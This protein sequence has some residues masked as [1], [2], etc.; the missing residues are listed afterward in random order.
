[1]NFEDLYALLKSNANP[2]RAAEMS[3]YMRNLF[4]FFGIPA[5]LRKRLFADCLKAAPKGTPIDWEFVRT[6]FSAVGRE[7]QYA[8]IYYL[9]SKKKLLSV[10]DL[11]CLRELIT[12]KSWW[13]TI[14]DMHTLVGAAALESPEGREILLA[15]SLDGDMW[16]RRAAIICQIGRKKK[17]DAGLL[18]AVIKNQFGQREFFINKAVGWSLREYSKTDKEWVREFIADSADSLAPLSVREASK[19]L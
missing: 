13:D 11:P 4:P 1:M 12:T 5:P 16:L 9:Q 7:L 2:E 6:C 19:Y 3:A 8:A 15:W 17:T 10:D 18:A 14:D